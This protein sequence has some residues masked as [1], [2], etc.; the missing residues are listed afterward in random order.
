ML[1]PAEAAS[2]LDR[3]TVA[4]EA[5]LA[6]HDTVVE[7]LIKRGLPRINVIEVEFLNSRLRSELDFVRALSEDI[8]SRRLDWRPPNGGDG[9][10]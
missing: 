8:K 9:E 3:R 7:S 2:L 6:A 4:L 10:K 1:P 5:K